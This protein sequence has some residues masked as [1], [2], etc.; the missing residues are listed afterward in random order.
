MV[1][2]QDVRVEL[3]LWGLL[4]LTVVLDDNSNLFVV[5]TGYL[6]SQVIR[7]QRITYLPMAL[8]SN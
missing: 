3:G 2:G 8:A 6:S 1:G 7:Y 4:V 5:I